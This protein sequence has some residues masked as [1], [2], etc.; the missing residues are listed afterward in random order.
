MA[1]DFTKASAAGVAA[2]LALF[3]S[4]AAAANSPAL[5]P[6]PL[7]GPAMQLAPF[8][9]SAFDAASDRNEWGCWGCGWGGGWYGRRGVRA[10]DVLAGAAIIGGITAIAVAASNNNRRRARTRDVIIVERDRVRDDRPNFDERDLDRRNFDRREAARAPR[11][12]GAGM[13]RSGANGIDRAVGQCVDRVREDVRID[14]VDLVERTAQGWM[15][16]GVLFN[17]GDFLCQISNDGRTIEVDYS[18]FD[19]GGSDAGAARSDGQW[20]DTR[21]ADARRAMGSPAPRMADQRLDRALASRGAPPPSAAI[22]AD[23]DDDLEPLVPLSAERLPAYPGGP[24]EG[25][26]LPPV[27]SDRPGIP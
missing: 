7:S 17:G 13:A 16:G 9:A 3:A 14:S 22:D 12:G 21:Y 20:S 27:P 2:S 5:A 25:E 24:V 26:E 10:G 8:S 15:V 11:M 19:A 1:L 18:G 23:I 4:P 6:V